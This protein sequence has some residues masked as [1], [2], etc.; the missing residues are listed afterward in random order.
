MNE[1]I[2]RTKFDTVLMHWMTTKKSSRLFFFFLLNLEML[3]QQKNNI[4]I[5][6]HWSYLFTFVYLCRL[7][8]FEFFDFC[9]N[10]CC[11]CC[12]SIW[13]VKMQTDAFFMSFFPYSVCWRHMILKVL[14]FVI[15]LFD[16]L[17]TFFLLH[18]WIRNLVILSKYFLA[19]DRFEAENCLFLM[20]FHLCV[21]FFL[22]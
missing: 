1:R 17:H 21:L 12:M 3:E 22:N 13:Y 10:C 20:I 4:H 6:S 8:Q 15:K 16:W 18:V 19:W 7:L 2:F 9:H 5:Y 14:V 11:C